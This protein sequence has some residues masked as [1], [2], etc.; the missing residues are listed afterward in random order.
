MKYVNELKGWALLAAVLGAG[1]LSGPV[2]RIDPPS[3]I[4]RGRGD[5]NNGRGRYTVTMTDGDQNW[6]VTIPEIGTAYEVSIPLKGSKGIGPG[7]VVVEQPVLTAA[8]KEI[9]GQRQIDARA[10]A[11]EPLPEG[12]PLPDDSS[13]TPRPARP[14]AGAAVPVGQ[15][16]PKA[17][18]LLTLA[19]VKD[20]YRT[21][22]YELALV[23]LVALER[24]YPEDER[25]MSMKGSLYEKLGRR[26]LAREAWEG[27]LALNP[28]NLQVAE[29]LQRL[30]K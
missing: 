21:R 2:G 22:N 6:E 9:V 1:C 16:T 18:Y 20:L 15:V 4:L 27:V 3:E 24:E 8:D 26:Q 12:T 30:G 14:R 29:A 11:E 23:E 25:I 7:G 5:G 10:R 28:Y 19:K 13:G 17:S